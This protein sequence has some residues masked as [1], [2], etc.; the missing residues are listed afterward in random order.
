MGRIVTQDG[1]DE[2]NFHIRFKGIE[3]YHEYD[4]IEA[5]KR[6]WIDKK[7]WM[8]REVYSL[9]QPKSEARRKIDLFLKRT[10]HIPTTKHGFLAWKQNGDI[11]K[12]KG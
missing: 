10:K 4:S 11:Y 5:L 8:K 2:A 9:E 7:S 12:K 1:T 6:D 3:R